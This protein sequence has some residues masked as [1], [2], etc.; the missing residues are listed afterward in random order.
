MLFKTVRHP[1]GVFQQR[2]VQILEQYWLRGRNILTQSEQGSKKSFNH[3]D[4]LSFV[5]AFARSKLTSPGYCCVSS[6]VFQFWELAHNKVQSV[7]LK[8]ATKWSQLRTCLMLLSV[9]RG[10][11]RMIGM[12]TDTSPDC[13]PHY[14]GSSRS[15]KWS[16]ITVKLSK[17]GE[18]QDSTAVGSLTKT[19]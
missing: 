10:N 11:R 15:F 12:L 19:C 4:T 6:R 13:R 9:W 2:F 3:R 8:R 7:H 5:L 1:L 14:K 17:S 16:E 18:W